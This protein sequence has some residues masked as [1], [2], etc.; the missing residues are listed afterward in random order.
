VKYEKL[1][2]FQIVARGS[3]LMSFAV[4]LPMKLYIFAVATLIWTCIELCKRN[5]L[6]LVL[7]R[8]KGPKH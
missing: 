6:D 5:M 1:G 2:I 7:N 4:E 3:W 8:D